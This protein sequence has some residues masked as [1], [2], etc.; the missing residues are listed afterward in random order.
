MQGGHRLRILH[1]I[2]DL[3]PGGAEN[4]LLALLRS[5][6]DG[7]VEVEAAALR[8]DGEIGNA[9]RA[10]GI[11]VHVFPGS[12]PPIVGG[13]AW[14]AR[15]VRGRGIQILHAHLALAAD[16]VALAPLPW[17]VMRAVTFHNLAFDAHP[18][19]TVRRR[20]RYAVEAW[21]LRNRFDLHAGVSRAVAQHYERN[22]GVRGVIVVPNAV[23]S[24]QVQASRPS[25]APPG[26]L[27]GVHVARLS[28]EKGHA[29]LFE[30]LG[31]M[32]ADM[33][34]FVCLVGDG[35]LRSR[36][37]GLARELGLVNDVAFLGRLPPEATRSV[38]AAADIALLP[39][40]QEGSPLAMIEA[41]AAGKP[42]VASAVGGIPEVVR[43]GET[44]LLVPPGDAAALADALR[45]LVEDAPLRARLGS[46][47]PPS[48]AA[49]EPNA[50]AAAWAAH[51][52][53]LLRKA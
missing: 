24:A 43:E 47:G 6:H 33:R 45:R 36:L 53:V 49:F 14:V 2:N 10:A 19:S 15:L 39:S 32:P 18:P 26:R 23:P 9:L 5:L 41:L 28:D 40:V 44:G 20:L 17:R 21:L 37:E 46:A 50:V 52:E 48:V 51:Y 13:P 7:G 38:L 16:V 30:A 11:P 3:R 12:L 25:V 42:L 8:S 35:P 22:V 1:V 4:S 29:I 31:R 27:L 34:P